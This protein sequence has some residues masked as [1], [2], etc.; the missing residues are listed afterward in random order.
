M[1]RSKSWICTRNGRGDRSRIAGVSAVALSGQ[2]QLAAIQTENQLELWDVV[3]GQRRVALPVQAFWAMRLCVA[4]GANDS[5]LAT[6]AG[7]SQPLRVWDTTT[8]KKLFEMPVEHVNALAFDPQ[9]Q[10]LAVAGGE[11][12]L[13]SATTGEIL[14]TCD[15]RDGSGFWHV[16]FSPDG[17]YLVS[18]GGDKTVRL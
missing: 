17:K 15:G 6:A 7:N 1:M 5:R 12:R 2:E 16:A 11:I 3:S 4:F 14:R 13:C 18:T 8:G 10:V 9:G